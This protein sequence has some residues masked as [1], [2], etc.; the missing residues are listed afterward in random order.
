MKARCSGTCTA[1]GK[2]TLNFK[3][4]QVPKQLIANVIV[5][6]MCHLIEHSHAPSF[7]PLTEKMM[8]VWEERREHLNSFEY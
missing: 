4:I 5:H 2:I 3:L 8:P 7:Y 6:E 1:K